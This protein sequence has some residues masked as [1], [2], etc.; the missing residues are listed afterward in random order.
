[1][2]TKDGLRDLRIYYFHADR[3]QRNEP[4]ASPKESLVRLAAE[5]AAPNTTPAAADPEA[6]ISSFESGG[7]VH[8]RITK[9]KAL[10]DEP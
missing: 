2:S 6:T 10:K 1:M 5:R 4:N 8:I 7:T 9:A 3:A